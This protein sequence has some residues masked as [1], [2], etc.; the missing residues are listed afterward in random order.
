MQDQLC[1]Q[2]SRSHEVSRSE[3]KSKGLVVDFDKV[4][5]SITKKVEEAVSKLNSAQQVSSSPKK[6]RRLD[7]LEAAVGIEHNFNDINFECAGLLVCSFASTA[8]R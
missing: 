4:Q 3:L 2:F 7:D 5:A 1:R 6:R 8:G